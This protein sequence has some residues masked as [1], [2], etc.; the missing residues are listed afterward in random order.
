[1]TAKG[2]LIFVVMGLE[3]TFESLDLK[4]FPELYLDFQG[5]QSGSLKCMQTW[6]S[7]LRQPSTCKCD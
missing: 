6:S 5:Q 4:V 7:F 3:V 1:M 2:K